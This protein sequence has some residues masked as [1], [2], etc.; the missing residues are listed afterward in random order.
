VL[1]NARYGSGN[2][3]GISVAQCSGRYGE[4]FL[5]N[6]IGDRVERLLEEHPWHSDFSLLEGYEKCLRVLT[7]RDYE[8]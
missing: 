6:E 4:E 8:D 2:G 7:Y 3:S 1:V 5:D